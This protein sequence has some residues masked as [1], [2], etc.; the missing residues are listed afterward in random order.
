MKAKSSFSLKDQLFNS[1]K[2]DYLGTLISQVFP[3]FA[4]QKFHQDVVIA[5]PNLELKERIA[6]IT[7]CLYRYLPDD[8]PKALALILGSMPP[9]LDPNKTDDDFGDF[10]FAPLSLFVATYGCTADHL[11]ISLQALKEITKRFSAE[12]AIRYF[13][14]AFPNETFAFLSDCARD[15]HYH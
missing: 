12:D 6:H 13:I 8:Y 14:N 4:Q 7:T 2:V 15:D 3:D 9:E 11:N 1:E 5:F 10:I